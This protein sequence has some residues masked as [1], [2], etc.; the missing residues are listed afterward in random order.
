MELSVTS[1]HRH[2]FKGAVASFHILRFEFET[3]GSIDLPAFENRRV[4]PFHL[5]HSFFVCFYQS[6]QKHNQHR[7]QLGALITSTSASRTTQRFVKS[8]QRNINIENNSTY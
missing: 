3:R 6:Q 4:A 2:S 5:T 1:I 7:E 8:I